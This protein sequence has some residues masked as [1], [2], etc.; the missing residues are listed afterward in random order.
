VPGDAAHLC[1]ELSGR[2]VVVDARDP[3][4]LRFAPAPLYNSFGECWTAVAELA[5]LLNDG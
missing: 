5:A 1:R 4:I 2:G 3:D